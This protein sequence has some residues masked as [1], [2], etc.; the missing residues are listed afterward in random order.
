MCIVF[1]KGVA[2]ALQLVRRAA[3]IKHVR[4]LVLPMR[5]I[6]HRLEFAFQLLAAQKALCCAGLCLLCVA[7]LVGVVR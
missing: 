4:S 2:D 6:V 1:G 3:H 5:V 7:A